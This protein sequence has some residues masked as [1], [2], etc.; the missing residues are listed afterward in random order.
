LWPSKAELEWIFR[1]PAPAKAIPDLMRFFAQREQATL[2]FWGDK[3][4]KYIYF[5]DSLRKAFPG[6]RVL[7][8][9]RDPRDTVLSMRDAWGRSLV[10]SSI[11]WRDAARIIRSDSKV[12]GPNETLVMHYEA[13]ATEPVSGLAK[14]A[15]W[16][17]VGF[18][19]E[20]V[21]RYSGDERWGA[22]RANQVLSTSI[23]RYRRILSEAEVRFVES[24]VFDEMTAWGYMPERA[25][26]GKAPSTVHVH[27]A[28]VSDGLRSLASYRADRGLVAGLKYKLR[29]FLV[30][31]RGNIGE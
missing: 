31:R 9:I 11:A 21:D 13:L 5:L 28:R 8:M 25:T 14:I 29:Q 18:S 1:D 4:P 17:G 22:V 19:E 20:A 23:G 15:E 30:T 6:L 7:F 2:A 24:I 12:H 26:E 3:T 16:L 27:F 10:R